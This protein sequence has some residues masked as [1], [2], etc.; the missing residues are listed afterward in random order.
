V[1]TYL[2][3]FA[4]PYKHA[5]HYTGKTKNLPARLKQHR[6]GTGARLLAVLNDAGIGW[7]IAATWEGDCE[8]TLKARHDAA[9]YC[10]DPECRD[11]RRK[12]SPGKETRS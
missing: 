7:E 2:I 8:K 11:R 12:P 9:R 5:R 4:R 6:N 10:P 3:H 1:I